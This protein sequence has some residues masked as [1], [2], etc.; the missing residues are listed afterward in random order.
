MSRIQS[1]FGITIFKR[2]LHRRLRDRG[3]DNRVK[4][5]Q[6]SDIRIK[7]ACLSLTQGFDNLEIHYVLQFERTS[8][9]QGAIAKIRKELGLYRRLSPFERTQ[10]L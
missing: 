3:L 5:T 1:Q 7:I 8:V 2:T 6:S 4:K 9:E 10:Q